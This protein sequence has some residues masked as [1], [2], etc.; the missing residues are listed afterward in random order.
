MSEFRQPAEARAVQSNTITTEYR[1]EYTARVGSLVQ[2]DNW[3]HAV[4]LEPCEWTPA[5]FRVSGQ[6]GACSAINVVL[7]GRTVQRLNAFTRGVRC[8]IEFVQDGEP[9]IPHAGW[10]LVDY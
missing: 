6:S 7:T 10:L 9:P 5:Q 1:N 4:P 3:G 8:R 2:I